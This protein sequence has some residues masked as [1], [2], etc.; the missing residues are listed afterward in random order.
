MAGRF[1]FALVPEGVGFAVTLPRIPLV[2]VREGGPVDL[3]RRERHRAEAIIASGRRSYG[4]LP[5]TLLDQLSERWAR[6][7]D[8]PFLHEMDSIGRAGMDRGTWFMNLCFEW[9]CTTGAGS[10]PDGNGVR[11]LRTLDWPFNGLGRELVVAHQQGAAGDYFNVTWPGFVGIVTAMAPGRFAA[12]INQA[13]VP[14]RGPGGI[15]MTL[16][17]D[18]LISRA[19]TFSS[20]RL[21]PVLLLR[22]VFETCGT[23]EEA[24]EML[25][26]TPLALPAFFTL[27]GTKPGEA[28]VIERLETRAFVHENPATV[29]NHWLTRGLNGRPRGVESHMR[30]TRMRE[31]IHQADLNFDWLMFPILNKE[32]RLAVMAN[33]ATGGL[34]VRGFEA[35]GPATEVFDLR[36]SDAC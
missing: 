7:R 17:F 9:A 6:R 4:A 15:S 8:L 20:D 28:C 36:E 3:L 24:R 30:L 5:I 12:A 14:F 18:W 35:D 26:D 10:D 19:R 31:V 21:P 11:L 29:A 1:S 25:R 27:A 16:V 33:A 2:D 34:Q 13:P 23:F 32:T 22:R